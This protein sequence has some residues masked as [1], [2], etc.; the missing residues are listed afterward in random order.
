MNRVSR[1]KILIYIY[2]FMLVFAIIFQGMPPVFSFL[3]DH[4][5]I[6]HAQAGA[7]MSVFA[8]PGILISIPGG[9]LT[10]TFGAKNV[11]IFALIVT[12]IGSVIVG[13]ASNFALLMLGRIISGIGALTIAIVAPQTLSHRFAKKDLGTAMGIFNTVMPLGTIFTLNLFNPLATSYGW[14]IPLLLSSVYCLLILLLFV[15]KYPNSAKDNP[16]LKESN[17]KDSFVSVKNVGWPL[18]LTAIIWMMYNAAAISFLT[19]GSDYYVSIGYSPSYAGFL[20]SLLM[21]G[22]LLFSTLVGFLTDRFGREQ[23]FIVFGGLAL[24]L[25]FW[26]VPRTGINPVLLGGLIGFFAPFIPAPVF[27][28]A[29][30]FSPTKQAGLGFGILSTCLNVGVLIGPYFVGLAYDLTKTY[31]LSFDLIA[32]FALFMVITAL[33][34]QRITKTKN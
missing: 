3:M 12:F 13:L 27:A 24:A 25:L 11:G 7:L 5:G 29:P 8:L 17:I 31:F 30:R 9:I 15:F 2:L 20:T 19:F 1:W 16:T 6:S 22:A 10:D 33:I 14:R 21:I 23:H 34:L 18:W 32:L 28:L 4:L 26:L